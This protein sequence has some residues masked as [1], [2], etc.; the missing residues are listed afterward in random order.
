MS[1]ISRYVLLGMVQE[2]VI[3]RCGMVEMCVFK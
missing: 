2:K 1:G 3:S